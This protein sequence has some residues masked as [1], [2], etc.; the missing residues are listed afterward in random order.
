MSDVTRLSLDDPQLLPFLP[1]LY[2]AWAD[3]ELDPEE[4]R[5]ICGELGGGCAE[6]LGP[7]VDP[8]QPPSERE[9][10]RMLRLLRREASSIETSEKLDLIGLGRRLAQAHRED[11]RPVSAAEQDALE[12]LAEQLGIAG[13]EAARQ[14]FA[15]R[16]RAERAPETPPSFD[17]AALSERLAGDWP[18]VRRRVFELLR[19]PE[20]RYRRGLDVE[21][22]REQVL[23]WCRRLAE[24]GFGGLSFPEPH[25]GA[26]DLGAFITAFE[27]VAFH[28]LSLLVKFGVQFGLFG[29]AILNLGTEKHHREYLPRVAS[30]ELPGC[31]AMTETSHGS[32]VADLETTATWDG[33]AGEFVIDTPS[34]SAARKDYIGNAARDGRLAVVFAQLL[35]GDE[36]HGVHAFLVPIRDE[37]GVPVPGVSITDCG[38]KMGLN[39]VDNGRLHFDEIRVSRHALLDRFASV[40]EEG[41]YESPIRSPSKRFFTMLGTLVGGRVSVALAANSASKSALTIAVRYAV[42]RRQFGPGGEQELKLLDYPSHRRRLLPRVATTYALNFALDQ[43]RRDYVDAM[44]PDRGMDEGDVERR[45]VE[46]DAAGLKAMATYHATDTIQACREACGGQ[47]FLSENRFAALKADTDVF[48]TFEGD[49][50]VLLQLV[51]KGMLSALRKRFKSMGVVGFARW[52]AARAEH[53]S[54]RLK[55]WR[56]RRTSHQHLQ[57]RDF[58]LDAF[59]WREEDLQTEAASRLRGLLKDGSDPTTAMLE[60]QNDLLAMAKARVERQVLER[61][62]AAIDHTQDESQRKILAEVCHLFAL[63][64]LEADR[65]YFLEHGYFGGI[66]SRAVSDEVDSLCDRLRPQALHLVD[67]FHIPDELLGAPIAR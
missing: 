11:H 19:E 17:V 12:L 20:F 2:V 1:M 58:H 30:L 8:D 56:T 46:E 38:H 55:P 24:Q 36:E 9:L 59:R 27:S 22:Y 49:N 7:W 32:N 3:G 43:L 35:V 40:S 64:R 37:E 5:A 53:E 25:G 54:A 61:F 45:R 65:A 57:D 47:G 14:L 34:R 10:G 62:V 33:A 39:G 60:T 44:R 23:A 42:R 16:R 48:M 29:G 4:I 15:S 66:K 50:T 18:E 52:I 6:R 63:S 21:A 13:T 26:G 67:A 28:D 41:D 51:A 31:F